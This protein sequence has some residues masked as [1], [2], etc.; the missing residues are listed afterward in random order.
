V[1]SLSAQYGG[2]RVGQGAQSEKPQDHTPSG[3]VDQRSVD[4]RPDAPVRPHHGGTDPQQTGEQTVR[5]PGRRE[6]S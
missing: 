4:V 5:V 1:R 6:I 2:V 3:P